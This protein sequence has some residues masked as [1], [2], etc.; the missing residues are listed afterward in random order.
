MPIWIDPTNLPSETA[1]EF[2]RAEGTLSLEVTI[3]PPLEDPP[4]KREAILF[5]ETPA[6]T[7]VTI[8]LDE[9]LRFYFGRRA[10]G[11]AAAYAVVD[12]TSL[13]GME[14]MAIEGF[15]SP[16]GLRIRVTDRKSGNSVS[17]EPAV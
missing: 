3:E 12:G 5:Y 11:M 15:W 16:L 17:S 9:R 2:D 7:L 10:P 6:K 13:I 1:A 14:R 4:D 8:E